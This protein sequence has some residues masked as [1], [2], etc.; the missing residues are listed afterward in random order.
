MLEEEAVGMKK[1]RAEQSSS[2]QWR[3]SKMR[4][5]GIWGLY[6]PPEERKDHLGGTGGVGVL[7]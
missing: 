5:G 3:E 4:D 6:C 1:G 2:Q 7:R